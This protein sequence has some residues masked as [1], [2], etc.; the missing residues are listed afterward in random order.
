[1]LEEGYIGETACM[2]VKKRWLTGHIACHQSL[3]QGPN[4][5]RCAAAELPLDCTGYCTAGQ[6]E[7][8]YSHTMW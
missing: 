8:E 6:E 2:R 5:L 1:M 4:D 7:F 3:S